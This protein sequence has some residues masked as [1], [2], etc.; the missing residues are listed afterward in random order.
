[1]KKVELRLAYGGRVGRRGHRAAAHH[2]HLASVAIGLAHI[3]LMEFGFDE[4]VDNKVY[5][6]LADAIVAGSDSLEETT[7][8]IRLIDSLDCLPSSWT[9]IFTRKKQRLVGSIIKWETLT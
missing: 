8:T 3:E 5:D 6:R 7:D 4:L 1:M 9:A 2:H